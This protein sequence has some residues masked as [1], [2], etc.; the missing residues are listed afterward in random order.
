VHWP[1]SGPVALPSEPDTKLG[2]S[3]QAG[4]RC[5]LIRDAEATNSQAIFTWKHPAPQV[6]ALRERE[7]ELPRR[8]ASS[9]R[10]AVRCCS[11][12]PWMT[13]PA[14]LARLRR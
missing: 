13:S 6:S 4:T 5:L 2:D 8:I 7:R 11:A 12:A 9:A 14:M 3:F 1:G 10:D